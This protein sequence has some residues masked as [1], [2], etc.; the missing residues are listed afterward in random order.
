M[1]YHTCGAI[2]HDM[3]PG[4]KICSQVI[5]VNRFSPSSRKNAVNEIKVNGPLL[6]SNVLSS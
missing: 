4:F 2:D 6:F 5:Y 3:L 1:R